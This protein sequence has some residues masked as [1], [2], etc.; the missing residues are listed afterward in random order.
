MHKY[1]LKTAYY[2]VLAIQLCCCAALTPIILETDAD[3]L[4]FKRYAYI[5][6]VCLSRIA[7][8]AQFILYPAILVKLYGLYGGLKAYSIGFT[9]QPMAY[10]LII[11]LD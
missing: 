1:S 4:D 7:V 10:A 11:L 9:C 2:V 6:I 8:G 3:E 5:V